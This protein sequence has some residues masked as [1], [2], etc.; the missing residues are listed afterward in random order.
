LSIDSVFLP[1]LAAEP[2]RALAVA[3]RGSAILAVQSAA[4]LS[5]RKIPSDGLVMAI[6]GL[7]PFARR[8][9]EQSVTLPAEDIAAV[10]PARGGVMR[11]NP[12][13][14]RGA[15]DGRISEAETRQTLARLTALPRQRGGQIAVNSRNELGGRRRSPVLAWFDNPSGRYLTQER[16]GSDGTKWATVAPADAATLRKRIAEVVGLVTAEGR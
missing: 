1:E 12:A 2:V 3:G 16:V 15:G 8:G 4:G 6:V 9:T 13:S 11:G 14:G 7:L 5:L 10:A